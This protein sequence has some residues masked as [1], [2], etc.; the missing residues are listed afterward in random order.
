M[1]RTKRSGK[2]KRLPIDPFKPPE[3]KV[4]TLPYTREH[5]RLPAGKRFWSFML[6]CDRVTEKDHYLNRGSPRTYRDALEDAIDLAR[7]RRCHTVKVLP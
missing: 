7:R 6:I 4:D 5:K 3:V 1:A 2:R